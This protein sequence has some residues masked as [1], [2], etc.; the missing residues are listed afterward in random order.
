MNSPHDAEPSETCTSPSLVHP[1]LVLALG[2]HDPSGAGI[3][4]DIEAAAS[5]GCHALTLVTCL[6]AQNTRRVEEVIP[7]QPSL[8]RRQFDLVVSD[9]RALGAC[10]IGLIP[11]VDVLMTVCELVRELQPGIPVVLDPVIAAG[12]G[13]PL[14]KDDVR[15]AMVEHL[16]PLAT[17][18]TPNAR[19]ARLLAEASGHRRVEDLLLE[20]NGWTLVKGADEP[21]PDVEHRLFQRGQLHAS[22]RWP[23]LSGSFHGSGCTLGTA[24][25]A[26]LAR[27][28]TLPVAVAQALD[29][30]WHAVA[31]ALDIGG[32]QYLPNRLNRQ[33]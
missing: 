22:Y 33:E 12:S 29:F 4:A 1:P 26:L 13:S 14:M 31:N 18:R 8:L 24:I 21:T 17:L 15:R 32:V 20:G 23:R 3:Q 30:T 11:S 6:T 5:F 28:E 27:G 2:G 25:A 9:T 19:E 7:V 10:K 16:W